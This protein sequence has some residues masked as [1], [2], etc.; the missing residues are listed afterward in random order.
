MGCST[1]ICVRSIVVSNIHIYV[2]GT[3]VNVSEETEQNLGAMFDS[4][5]TMVS[6][7]N[8]VHLRNIGE[9]MK[10]L[11]EDA[12]KKVMHHLVISQIDYCNVLLSGIQQDTMAKL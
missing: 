11:T 10:L 5:C 3:R 1:G 2:A 9:V 6:N 7:L 12:T 4:N 8:S